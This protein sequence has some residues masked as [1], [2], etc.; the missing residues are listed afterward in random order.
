MILSRGG[1]GSQASQKVFDMKHYA[2]NVLC[3]WDIRHQAAVVGP[4]FDTKR[5]KVSPPSRGNLSRFEH[6]Q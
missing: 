1:Q 2:L 5:Y 6:L 3:V 4:Y